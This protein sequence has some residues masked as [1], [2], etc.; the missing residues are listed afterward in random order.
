M[1]GSNVGRRPHTEAEW[2]RDVQQQIKEFKS[3]D[4]VRLGSWVLSERDGEIVA[5]K[6]GRAPV[7]L[8]EVLAA[9]DTSGLRR[10]QRL[11]TVSGT[12]GG[13]LGLVY[14]GD[15]LTVPW[16]AS[17]AQLLAAF[18][19]L[20][21]SYTALDFNVTGPN[22]GPWIVTHPGGTLDADLTGLT[23]SAPAV[24]ITIP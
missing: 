20:R 2:A 19:G 23:G 9:A 4:T 6:P 7:V 15:P 16:N 21:T 1:S 8:T 3:R 18:L 10:V 14:R 11:I 24:D 5:T 13:S 22:G 12:T 17:Q